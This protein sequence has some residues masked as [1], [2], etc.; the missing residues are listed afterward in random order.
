MGNFIKPTHLQAKEYIKILPSF[1]IAI[2]YDPKKYHL[3]DFKPYEL[4]YV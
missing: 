1:I 4:S 3:N 2:Y